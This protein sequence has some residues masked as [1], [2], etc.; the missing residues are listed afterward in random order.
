MMSIELAGSRMTKHPAC[1]YLQFYSLFRELHAQPAGF[2]TGSA[3]LT[4][5]FSHET[6]LGASRLAA[7]AEAA[8]AGD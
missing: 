4:G 8:F 2:C 6:L 5:Y 7:R 3:R 1:S